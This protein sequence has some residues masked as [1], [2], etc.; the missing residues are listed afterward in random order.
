M[1]GLQKNWTCYQGYLKSSGKVLIFT[2]ADTVYS[3]QTVPLG[4]GQT[5]HI[6]DC[7]MLF[8]CLFNYQSC[9][10]LAFTGLQRVYAV[11]LFSK[12]EKPFGVPYDDWVAKYWNWDVGQSQFTP[13]P[14]GCIINNS[15][16]MA[17]LVETTL[18]IRF[19]ASHLSRA[20]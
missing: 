10:C 16:S 3:R 11:Q 1:T 4:V 20:S 19:V 18:L 14:N 6:S 8:P 13:K 5:Y 7:S 12:N 9:L 2:D 15:S 17:M